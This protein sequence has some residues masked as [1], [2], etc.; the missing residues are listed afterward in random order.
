MLLEPRPL[1]PNL[2]RGLPM[3]FRRKKEVEEELPPPETSDR[4]IRSLWRVV[5]VAWI[6]IMLVS[7]LGVV[8]V[9]AETRTKTCISPTTFMIGARSIGHFAH[10]S[11]MQLDSIKHLKKLTDFDAALATAG[12]G[13]AS[14]D[15][16]PRVAQLPDSTV[17][18]PAPE[19]CYFIKRKGHCRTEN[20]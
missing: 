18:L 15:V 4:Y 2:T 11:F 14:E 19:S 9:Y 10:N 13:G 6:P 1:G 5:K 3:F 20:N 7:A 16:M 8:E 17:E 12:D